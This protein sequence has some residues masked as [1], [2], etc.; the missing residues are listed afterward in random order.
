MLILYA[1]PESLYCAKLR[2][3]LRHKQAQWQE[4]MP[5]G[6][7]GSEAYRSLIPAGTM[8][9]I[10]VEDLVLADSE[11]IA[12]YLEETISEP[13]MLPR[14]AAARARCRERSRFHDTRLE[15]EVRKLFAH[16]GKATR[17]SDVVDA[18]SQALNQRFEELSRLLDADSTRDPALFSLADCGFPVS[19][20]WID[21]FV[22]AMG[23]ELEWPQNVTDYRREIESHAAVGDELAAYA[24]DM[25]DWLRSKNIDC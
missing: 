24:P 19:F 20:A 16:V 13:A 10:V 14:D 18:Q 15:P 4:V 5:E 23:L 6:G 25:R 1:S 12:E 7:C 2:I 17:G 8:P 21:A 3:L 9:A 22:G 11:A